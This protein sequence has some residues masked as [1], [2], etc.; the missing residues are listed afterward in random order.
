MTELTINRKWHMPSP[1][2]FT[3][4]PIQEILCRYIGKDETWVDP[5]GGFNSPAT[6]TNDLNPECPTNY[7]MDSLDF[8]KMIQSPIDGAIYDP[9]YSATQLKRLYTKLNRHVYMND[10]N[11]NFYARI[12]NELAPKI[13]VGGYVI[14][15]GW[16]SNGFGMK[17]GF[18]IVEI[19]LVAHGSATNDTIVT[20]ERKVRD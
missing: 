19:L 12:K 6:I 15:C 4:Q 8:C 7:H 1:W 13:K 3:I 17:R 20:V 16:N 11:T 14:S 5:F 2:T 18:E 9:P 10:T